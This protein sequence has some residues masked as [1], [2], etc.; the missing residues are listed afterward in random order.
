MFYILKSQ[1]KT[2]LIKTNQTKNYFLFSLNYLN[3]SNNIYCNTVVINNYPSRPTYKEILAS[4]NDQPATAKVSFHSNRSPKDI[5]C[6]NN[7]SIYASSPSLLII[8]IG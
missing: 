6:S 7:D 5:L 3:M 8:I 2:N 4:Q 1:I